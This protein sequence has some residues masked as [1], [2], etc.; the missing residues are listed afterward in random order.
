MNKLL[1]TVV[2]PAYNSEKYIK[3]AVDSAFDQDVELEVIVINDASTDGTVKILEE[4]Q[5]RDN[6]TLLENEKNLGV[7]AS[8]NLGVATS[9]GEY[10]AFLD[11]DDWWVADKLSKQLTAMKANGTIIC[12]TARELVNSDGSSQG[13]I[14]RIKE[15]ITYQ[16]MMRQNWLNC[17]AVVV[18]T[19]VIKEFPMQHDDSHEDYITWMRILKKYKVATGVDEPLLKYRVSSVGKSGSKRTSAKM[20][21][22]AYRYLDIGPVKA[23]FCFCSYAINGVRKYY[24]NRGEDR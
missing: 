11:A 14:V 6:F 9:R 5:T 1:V 4:Y 19:D 8:R 16:M 10:I 15:H 23:A 7:A 12:S 2:I 21:Y 18:R 17:S 13:K 3:K 22:R 20:M 24:F